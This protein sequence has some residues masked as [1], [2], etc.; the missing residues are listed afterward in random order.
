MEKFAVIQ[1]G[2]KQYKVSAGEKIKIEKILGSAGDAVVFDE[3]LLSVNGEDLEIGTPHISG[4]VEGK[5]VKQ[6][7]DEKKIIFRYHPKTRY[8]KK[9]GHTQLLTEVEIIKV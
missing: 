5:I 3:V 4:K 2:G 6:T 9:K 8:R 1:T 7:K